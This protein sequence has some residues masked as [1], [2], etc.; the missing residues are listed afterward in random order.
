MLRFGCDNQSIVSWAQKLSVQGRKISWLLMRVLGLRLACNET[1]LLIL[2]AM[3]R[4]DKAM[5]NYSMC[6]FGQK[7]GRAN[8]L[9]YHNSD[10]FFLCVF[11]STFPFATQQDI[12]WQLFCV[13]TKLTFLTFSKLLNKPQPMASWQQ[14][15]KSGGSIGH[16]EQLLPCQHSHGPPP[17]PYGRKLCHQC[18][19]C[20][21]C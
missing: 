8:L 17:H 20:L 15:T 4:E 11:A 18:L 19:A 1:S 7:G 12:S 6:S 5:A 13:A 3:A 9:T 21:C 2:V 10:N 16:V 14:I